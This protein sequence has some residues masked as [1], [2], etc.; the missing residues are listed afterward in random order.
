M[1][2]AVISNN[3][4]IENISK[5]AYSFFKNKLTFKNPEFEKKQNMGFY[6]GNIPM[7][8][9]MYQEIGNKFVVPFGMLDI[10]KLNSK[11]FEI[12]YDNKDKEIYSKIDYKSQ[13]KLYSY[14]EEAVSKAL[15]YGHG[16]IVAPC[17]AGKTQIGIELIARYGLRTLWLTHTEDLLNQSMKRAKANLE[18]NKNEYGTITAGRVNIGTA[19]TFATVQTMSKIDLSQ[20]KD[21]WDVVIVDECHH[22]VGTPSKVMMF[23]KV[24][25]NLN[26]LHKFGLTA[27]PQRADG[28]VNCMFSMLGRKICEIP[29]T[30][31]KN[32]T[33]PVKIKIV[34]TFFSPNEDEILDTDGTIIYTN[35]VNEICRNEKRNN[36]IIDDIEKADGICL[37]LTDRIEHVKILEQALKKRNISCKALSSMAHKSERSKIIGEFQKGQIKVLIATYQLAKEGLDIPNL[38]YLFLATPQK[39]ENTVIQSVGRVGRKADGKQFGIVYDYVDNFGMLKGWERIRKRIYKKNNFIIE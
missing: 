9:C 32:T 28:L 38:K 18:I 12:E 20:Y 17:G 1:L 7:N 6:V 22:L 5:Q 23:Y 13:I 15:Q 37:V 36:L 21:Y 14:Q 31:V 8:L 19:L 24:V 16:V 3:I 10:I 30:A 27:T 34:N 39:N 25:S 2:K 4:T 11:V 29:K 33:C 26:A 35:L